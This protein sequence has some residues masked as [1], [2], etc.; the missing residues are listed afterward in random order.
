MSILVKHRPSC[1]LEALP[2]QLKSLAVNA[3]ENTRAELISVM[4]TPALDFGAT[5]KL[6]PSVDSTVTMRL[7]PWTLLALTL[8]ASLAFVLR[9]WLRQKLT[10]SSSTEPKATLKNQ[11]ATENAS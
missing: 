10:R 6:R 3:V 11:S 9:E 5:A 8:L 1:A 2:S 7:L 4:M